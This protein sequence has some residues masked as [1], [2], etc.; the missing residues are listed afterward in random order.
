MQIYFKSHKLAAIFNQQKE[1][2]KSY[3]QE[4]GRI[5]QRRIS[6]LMAATTLAEV[7][8][9]PPEKRHELK[10]KEKGKFAVYLKQPYRLIFE[11]AHNPLPCKVDGGLDLK[12]ITAITILEMED[13]H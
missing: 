8:Q 1:L 9:K 11:P 3:G 13:Y 4:Q 12:K 7:S 5:I 2:Y 6:V 10:G